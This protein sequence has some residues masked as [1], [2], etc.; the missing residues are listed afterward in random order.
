MLLRAERPL[1]GCGSR[2]PGRVSCSGDQAPLAKKEVAE[3]VKAEESKEAQSS[4][5]IK[6][7]E[8]PAAERDKK[9][10]KEKKKSLG[11]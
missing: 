10:K 8:E 5:D 11:G 6:V 1:R 7:K 2:G 9:D 3:E 4:E